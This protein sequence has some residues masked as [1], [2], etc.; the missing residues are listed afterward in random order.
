MVKIKRTASIKG[1]IVEC[2]PYD[3]AIPFLV[4]KGCI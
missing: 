2:L 4:L 1:K 3:L